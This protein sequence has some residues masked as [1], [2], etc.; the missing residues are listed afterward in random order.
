MFAFT[1]DGAYDEQLAGKGAIKTGWD[2]DETAQRLT[3]MVVQETAKYIRSSE[4]FALRVGAKAAAE[5]VAV[6]SNF[7]F[8]PQRFGS[9]ER[10]LSRFVMFAKP[11]LEALALEVAVPTCASRKAW[12]QSILRQ[13]DSGAW[14]MIAMLADLADDCSRFVWKLDEKR[15]DPMEFVECLKQFREH[16]TEEYIRGRMWLRAETYTRRVMEMLDVTKVVQFGREVTILERPSKN[17]SELCQAH[18]A[19]VAKGL[20]KY[21]QAQFPDFSIQ[22]QFVCFRITANGQH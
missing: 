1:P 20:L 17:E 8:A 6:V 16:L 15:V 7:S 22:A 11:L 5:A 13:L 4:R 3:K 9:R 10:P 14:C 21:L 12:A 19:N 2:S 18:V